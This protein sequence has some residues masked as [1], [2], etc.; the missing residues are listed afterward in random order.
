M[1]LDFLS[2]VDIADVLGRGCCSTAW[3][4]ANV[5]I[6]HWML[7]LYEER[8]QREVWDAN[9]DAYIA[10]GIAFP[11]G[12]GQVV[13]GGILLSGHWNFSSAVGSSQWNMLACLVRDGEKVVD[14]RICLVPAGDYEVVDDWQV[15]GLAGTGSM[16]VRILASRPKRSSPFSKVSSPVPAMTKALGDRPSSA[17]SARRRLSRPHPGADGT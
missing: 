11:Q 7:A 9:P 10:S 15:M 4:F 12:R 16:S 14:Y 5:A 1:E 3:A 6:H 13:D 17:S 8:A 2:I